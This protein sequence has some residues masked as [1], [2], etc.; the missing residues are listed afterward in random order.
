MPHAVATRQQICRQSGQNDC[1]FP[2]K[3]GT[4]GRGKIKT[5][6]SCAFCQNT[7]VLCTAARQ[8]GVSVRL[9]TVACDWLGP[10]GCV[11]FPIMS[12]TC[13]H[14]C[15]KKTTRKRKCRLPSSSYPVPPLSLFPVGP[16]AWHHP[17]HQPGVST[18][19]GWDHSIYPDNA[20]PCRV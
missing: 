16:T 13:V 17:P 6:Y 7:T 1:K 18:V 15:T 12:C 2:H 19:R 14:R 10:S 11:V 9:C 8:R 4:Y 3:P 5:Q 20:V